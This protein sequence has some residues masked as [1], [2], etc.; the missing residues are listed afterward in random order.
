MENWDYHGFVE[1]EF[2]TKENVKERISGYRKW[3]IANKLESSAAFTPALLEKFA[4]DTAEDFN[5]W[6]SNLT[7]LT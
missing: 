4:D 5:E 7:G 1:T 6:F 2:I 3:L